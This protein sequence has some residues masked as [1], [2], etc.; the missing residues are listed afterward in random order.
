MSPQPDNPVD[1][2]PHPPP[3]RRSAWTM[4]QKIIRAIWDSLGRLIWVLV[5]PARSALIRLFGGTVGRGCTFRRSVRITIPWNIHLGDRVEVGDRVILYTLGSITI[6]NE[7]VIDDFAHLCA[8]THD[9]RDSRF[10][11]LTPPINI[12]SQCFIGIDAYIGP[13]VTLGDR[14]RVH[15]R[16]SVYKSYDQDM[17]LRGNPARPVERSTAQKPEEVTA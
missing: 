4:K 15:P 6:G 9:L 17:E 1:H 12:G 14:C 7:T 8:G 3:K 16:A 13:D 11:L 5:P 2:A 10:P